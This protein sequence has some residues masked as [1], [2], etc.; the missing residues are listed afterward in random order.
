MKLYYNPKLK[1]LA[2]NLRKNMSPPEIILWN[3][4][5]GKKI[6]YDFHRQKPIGNFIADFFC[7]KLNLIIEVDGEVHVDKGD[8]DIERQ[9]RLEALGLTV[10]RFTAKDV[11]QNLPDVIETISNYIKNFEKK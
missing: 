9:S 7:S 10:M 3:Q 1:M 5:K 2:R 4:L 11:I 6:G 8:G